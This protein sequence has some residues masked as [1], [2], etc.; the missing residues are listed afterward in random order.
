MPTGL[1]RSTKRRVRKGPPGLPSEVTAAAGANRE[2][3]TWKTIV[4]LPV[5]MYCVL[6]VCELM[7]IG[8]A[9]TA[10]FIIPTSCYSST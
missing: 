7:V 9:F 4:T 10:L 3:R 2:S 5:T 1:A 8:A 6:G